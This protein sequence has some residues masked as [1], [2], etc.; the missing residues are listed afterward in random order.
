MLNFSLSNKD[1]P[2]YKIKAIYLE[3]FSNFISWPEESKIEDTQLN[4]KI[5]V[6]GDNPFNGVLK[7]IYLE[8][9]IKI[10]NKNVELNYISN[11]DEIKN[12]H[13]LFITDSANSLIDD[14]LQKVENKPVL[15]IA[16]TPGMAKKGA[17]INFYITDDGKLHFEINKN[18]AAISNI[19]IS[20]RLLRIA[21]LVE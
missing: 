18:M 5:T 19:R 12:C 2:I 3:K 1:N 21:K 6:I 8:N 9:K 17:H 20:S 15:L 14:I 11:T 7:E 16:D 13:I 4:F 10:L